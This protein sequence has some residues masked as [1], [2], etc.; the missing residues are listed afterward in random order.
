MIV[1]LAIGVP[2]RYGYLMN[3]NNN[4]GAR[5]PRNAIRVWQSDE[6]I[7]RLSGAQ[8]TASLRA[9]LPPGRNAVHTVV[10]PKDWP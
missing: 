10:H 1:S 7:A 9:C 6:T 5:I 2:V 8:L 3:A 4:P